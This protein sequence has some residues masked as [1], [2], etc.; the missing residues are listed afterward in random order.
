[1]LIN[2]QG[3]IIDTE[4]IYM[5]TPLKEHLIKD[6]CHNFT[7]KIL[8]LNQKELFIT[9]NVCYQHYTR[10]AGSPVGIEI[11]MPYEDKP[12]PKISIYK[13]RAFYTSI[14]EYWNSSKSKIPEIKL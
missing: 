10:K 5:I 13:L 1:M 9:I 6:W 4:Q 8:F 11:N 7:F 3:N 12:E 14:I 2:I